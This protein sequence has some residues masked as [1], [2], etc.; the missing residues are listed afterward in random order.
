MYNAVIAQL[1]ARS[2]LAIGVEGEGFEHL[3][4]RRKFGDLFGLPLGGGQARESEL[5]VRLSESLDCARQVLRALAGG[6]LAGLIGTRLSR[7]LSLSVGE[8]QAFIARVEDR[9]GQ[10][11]EGFRRGMAFGALAPQRGQRRGR[12]QVDDF[13]FDE[14]RRRSDWA[15]SAFSLRV[16]VSPSPRRPVARTLRPR[17][18]ERGEGNQLQ[19]ALRD[20]EQAL[21]AQL[22]RRRRQDHAAQFGGLPR[23]FGVRLGDARLSL[24]RCFVARIRGARREQV[25]DASR[26]RFDLGAGREGEGLQS[27]GRDQ[28]EVAALLAERVLQQQRIVVK[29]FALNALDADQLRLGQR[30]V[31]RVGSFDVRANLFQQV[32][33]RFDVGVEGRRLFGSIFPAEQAHLRGGKVIEFALQPAFFGDQLRVHAAAK[34]DLGFG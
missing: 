6:G 18:R 15:T 23:Q 28:E 7:A 8:F 22:R 31:A 32:E 2:Q 12:R 30:G 25:I 4:G 10:D 11:R 3:I 34:V 13:V 24:L 33:G 20:Y 1:A 17:F 26:P 29:Q 14:Q 21:L 27:R 5:V 19:G 9:I 16:L